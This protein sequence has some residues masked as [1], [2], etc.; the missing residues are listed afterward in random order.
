MKTVRLLCSRASAALVMIMLLQVTSITAATASDP[1]PSQEVAAE[2][3]HAAEHHEAGLDQLFFPAINFTIYLFIIVRFVI[4][5]LRE[6]L[7]RR[8]SDIMRSQSESKASLS[9][10]QEKLLASK[11]RLAVLKDE[12]D[13]IRRDLLAIA[14]RQA[15]RL[16]VQAEETG[17]RRLTDA[18]LLSEQESWRAMEKLR[19]SLSL[20]TSRLAEE[21]ILNALTPDDQRSF[22]QQFLKEASAR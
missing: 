10:A 11:E 6:Y 1:A 8:H 14:T 9:R 15:E 5:A 3:G 16:R 12:T 21:R 22:I 7:R 19:S 2:R 13:A 18:A 17:A 20:A 4:P